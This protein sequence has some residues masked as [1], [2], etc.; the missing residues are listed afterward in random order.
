MNKYYEI[1][2]IKELLYE[3]INNIKIYV[4]GNINISPG[5]HISLKDNNSEIGYSNLLNFYDSHDL[6]FDLPEMLKLNMG[7]FNNKNCVYLFDLKVLENYRGKGLSKIL[8]E[9]CHELS[10]D[11]GVD[12]VIL[13]TN[14]NNQVAQNLYKNLGYNLHVSDGKNDLLYKKL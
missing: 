14:C 1:L 9:K 7:E 6:D 11:I 4:S 12:Y 8:M 2:R 3:N 13:I 5:V 10:Q